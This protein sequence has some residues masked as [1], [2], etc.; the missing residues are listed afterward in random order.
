MGKFPVTFG[1]RKS[2]ANKDDTDGQVSSFRVLERTEVTGVKS[3]D[4]GAAQLRPFSTTTVRPYSHVDMVADEDNMFANLRVNR[5]VPVQSPSMT[6][7]SRTLYFPV[8]P[9]HAIFPP[10]LRSPTLIHFLSF[11]SPSRSRLQTPPILRQLRDRN[12]QFNN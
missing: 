6:H 5:Y 10:T 7:M 3:F 4:G 2:A 8:H 11:L 9:L 1:K 12:L